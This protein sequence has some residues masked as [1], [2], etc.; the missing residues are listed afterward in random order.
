MVC[1]NVLLA[2]SFFPEYFIMLTSRTMQH[3]MMGLVI[4]IESKWIWEEVAMA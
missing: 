2:L 3:Q 1:A 4:D